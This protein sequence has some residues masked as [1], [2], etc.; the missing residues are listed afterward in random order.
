MQKNL[1]FRVRVNR[2]SRVG[3]GVGASWRGMSFTILS[4]SLISYVLNA[5]SDR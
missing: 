3:V 4:M 1:K 5:D 2:D